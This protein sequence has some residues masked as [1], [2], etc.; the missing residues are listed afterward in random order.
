MSEHVLVL[1]AGSSSL[2]FCVYR[3]PGEG[4]WRADTRGR[5]E[6]I[7]TAPRFKASDA[8][9]RVLAEQT[10]ADAGGPCISRVGSRVS[11]WVIP[12]NEEL[13]IAWHTSSLLGIDQRAGHAF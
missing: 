8:E 1:N 13:V 3:R 10:L 12:T 2:K 6:G 7:G 5:V 9:G 4:A 11:A